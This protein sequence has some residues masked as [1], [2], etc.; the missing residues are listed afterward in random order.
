MSY[1]ETDIPSAFMQQLVTL[2]PLPPIAPEGMPYTPTPGTLYLAVHH[3]PAKPQTSGLGI[4]AQNFQ[5][6]FY[7]I[8]VFGPANAGLGVPL[9]V[10]GKLVQLF[11]RGTRLSYGTVT[12][13][14]TLSAGVAP[15]QS[16][17]DWV[18]VPVSIYYWA[19]TAN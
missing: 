19:F 18:Q 10:A 2:S 17:D 6:G 12:Q 9:A 4:N 3:M 13:M 16:D 5:K 1:V 7:Q 14:E 8:T 11:K 15:S